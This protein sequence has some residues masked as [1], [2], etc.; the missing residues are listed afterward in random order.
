LAQPR[1]VERVSLL[2]E[3]LNG[4]RVQRSHLARFRRRG[5]DKN[6]VWDQK[7]RVQVHVAGTKVG[8][9]AVFG[10]LDAAAGVMRK[11]QPQN[12]TGDRAILTTI[13][14]AHT[15]HLFGDVGNSFAAGLYV[16]VVEF[17]LFYRTGEAPKLR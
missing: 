12:M 4:S 6:G 1:V 10:D 5:R 13:T 9:Y 17:G 2:D 7:M 8:G 14:Q 15:P 11:L 16:R 3:T